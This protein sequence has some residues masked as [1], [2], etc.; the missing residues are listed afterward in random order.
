MALLDR[1]LR[2]CRIW[3]RLQILTAMR[4]WVVPKN[5][6]R[7]HHY[8][9]Q[10]LLRNFT[11]ADGKIWIYDTERGACRR[12]NPT[13]AGFE[14]D[15]YALKSKSE[16]PNY[17]ALE[18]FLA[19]NIDGPGADAIG[20]LLKHEQ[21]SAAKW[22]DFLGFVAAQMQR[23][24]AFFDRL[25]A[26]TGPAMQESFERMSKFHTPFRETVRKRLSE[27]G[28]TEQQIVEQFRLMDSGGYKV[29]PNR[30]FVMTRA[31]KM[32]ELI[33]AELQE[34]QWTILTL[35][36]GEPDL[37]M[38]DHP[39]TLYD[40]GPDDEPPGPLGLRNPNI[41]LVMPL[42]RRAVAIAR[43]TG[44]SSF[45][46]LCAGCAAAI[47]KRTLT[48]ARR[49][50][51]APYQSESLLAEAVKL[52]GTGPKVRVRRVPLGK[53]LMIVHEYR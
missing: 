30:A 38:S 9:P 34:M 10:L 33:H 31:L 23:T 42:S 24:P 15:L 7:N 5:V 26:T 28:A 1:S 16:Q 35:L 36:D 46:Q 22:M 20:R 6:P 18:K 25:S 27:S 47:N 37:I 17:G 8:V 3:A 11:D 19:V 2:Q 32:I 53:G 39:V 52:R 40:A 45:G 14:R 13:S 49:F 41:E 48:Y 21:L 44:P 12:G 29:R 51:F 4:N 43:H 50:I